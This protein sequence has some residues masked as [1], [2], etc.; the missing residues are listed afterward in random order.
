[1]VCTIGPASSG[2]GEG[3]ASL[4]V[5]IPLHSSDS[6]WRARAHARWHQSPV[7]QCSLQHIVA[8]DFQVKQAVCQEA[9]QLG[10]VV[11]QRTHGS[12]PS[13]LPSPYGGVQRWD[14]N[15]QLNFTKLGRIKGRIVHKCMYG[16]QFKNKVLS[17][18]LTQV[19][20]P[21]TSHTGLTTCFCIIRVII[22]LHTDGYACSQSASSWPW[23]DQNVSLLSTLLPSLLQSTAQPGWLTDSTAGPGLCANG[24]LL[25]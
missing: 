7:V 22:Q 12:R 11:F 6:L 18:V 21:I 15:Y 2:L 1:M 13:P 19:P 9:V 25:R 10:R 20:I 23:P 4:D 16:S 5:L 14:Y 24:C 8:A 17:T 3:L